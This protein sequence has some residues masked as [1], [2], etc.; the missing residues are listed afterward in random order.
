MF[1]ADQQ[2]EDREWAQEYVQAETS[3]QIQPKFGVNDDFEDRTVD[4][5]RARMCMGV[6]LGGSAE[7]W[8]A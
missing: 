6:S 8:L 4:R 2:W 5:S 1:I 7:S 3:E